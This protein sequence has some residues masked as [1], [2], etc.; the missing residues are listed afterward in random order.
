VQLSTDQE[1]KIRQNSR[2]VD[3]SGSG[4]P[5]HRVNH[6]NVLHDGEESSRRLEQT[7]EHVMMVGS[8]P[9][10][11]SSEIHVNG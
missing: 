9:Y 2:F 3:R 5:N 1:P 7:E 8:W 10:K 4:N 6:P 11:V